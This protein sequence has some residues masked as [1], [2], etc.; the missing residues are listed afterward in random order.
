MFKIDRGKKIKLYN[1]QRIIGN[2]HGWFYIVNTGVR[3][4]TFVTL[5]SFDPVIS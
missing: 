2:S 4:V 1:V 5:M 3:R